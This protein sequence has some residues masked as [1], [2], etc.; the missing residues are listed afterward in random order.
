M[1]EYI[2]LLHKEPVSLEEIASH[3]YLSREYFGRFFRKNMDLLIISCLTR[4]S[5][6][7]MGV[8]RGRSEENRNNQ[9]ENY[10]YIRYTE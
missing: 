3:F 10:E 1:I 2:E 8:R 7:S 5:V 6:K 4:C 9:G